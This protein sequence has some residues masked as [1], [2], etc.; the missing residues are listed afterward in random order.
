M[1]SIVERLRIPGD[2]VFSTR[3][4][5]QLADL[6]EQQAARIKELEAW[7][8]S[9]VKCP[10]GA[11]AQRIKELETERDSFHM[12]YRMKCDEETKRLEEQ[13]TALRQRIADAPVVAW[14]HEVRQDSDVITNAVKHVWGGVAV[15]KEAQY[16]IPLISK[17]DL[18]N[19]S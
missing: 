5:W 1:N 17:E 8:D 4:K 16:T 19:E 3:K 2:E 7:R 6:I 10:E 11:A 13:L 9:W 18:Q 14:L 15:G 12:N